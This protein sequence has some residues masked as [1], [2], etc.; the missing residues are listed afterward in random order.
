MAREVRAEVAVLKVAALRFVMQDP[1]RLNERAGQRERVR[2]V[3]ELVADRAPDLLDP[4][5]AS[6][7]HDA[8]DDAAK[9]RVIVDQ[10]ATMTETRLERLDPDR[11]TIR[12]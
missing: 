7:W 1:D 8:Q 11:G 4:M 9:E 5:F 3:A 10:M 6:F 12:M 2:R